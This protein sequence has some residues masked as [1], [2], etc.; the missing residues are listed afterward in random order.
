MRLLLWG[1]R[2]HRASQNHYATV[3]TL[4]RACPQQVKRTKLLLCLCASPPACAECLPINDSVLG[5]YLNSTISHDALGR[6]P[7]SSAYGVGNSPSCDQRPAFWARFPTTLF[8]SLAAAAAVKSSQAWV[9]S[10]WQCCW[11][12]LSL[13][14]LTGTAWSPLAVPSLSPSNLISSSCGQTGYPRCTKTFTFILFFSSV[15]PQSFDDSWQ[16]LS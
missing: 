10:L 16:N 11:L 5:W 1:K 15:K 13:T 12:S 8:L 14:H 3:M 4:M 9:T 2:C 7:C 6:R